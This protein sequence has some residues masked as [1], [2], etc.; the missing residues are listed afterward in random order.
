MFWKS[1]VVFAII[2]CDGGA[3]A[4]D[5]GL[6]APWFRAYMA[7]V[8]APMPVE[9]VLRG[10]ANQMRDPA[11][12]QFR[13]IQAVRRADRRTAVYGNLNTHNAFGGYVGFRAFCAIGTPLSGSPR[14]SLSMAGGPL[15]AGDV[16]RLC[17]G[18]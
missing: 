16:Y 11:S 1:T 5:S 2:C 3:R 7:R 13:D 6:D 18:T 4:A 9:S 12:T 8:S 14:V 15:D 10:V 17:Q